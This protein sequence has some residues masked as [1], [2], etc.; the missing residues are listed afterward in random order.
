M[1]ARART[2]FALF[3][4]VLAF[5]LCMPT[6]AF[7]AGAFDDGGQSGALSSGTQRN[8]G[9]LFA[10]AHPVSSTDIEGDLYWA[11]QTLNATKVN[12]GTS[13]QGSLL[14]AGK[15]LSFSDITVAGSLRAAGQEITISR[16]QISSNITIA[17]QTISLGSD[18]AAKGLYASA[19]DITVAGSYEGGMLS[20]KNV[21]L[22]GVVE[23]DLTIS[24]QT[25]AIS[26]KAQVNGTLIVPE[27][28]NITIAE[29]AQ[30]PNVSY[31]APVKTEQPTMFDD[32]L[33]VLYTCMAHI[34]LVGLFFLVIRKSLVRS[35]NMART[36]LLKML[37]AGLVIFIVAPILCIVLV[38]P[39]ITIPIVV[40]MLIVML[41][42]ALF[43]LPFAG[44]ALGLMLLGKRMNPVLAAIIGTVALTILVYIPILSVVTVLFCIFFTTGYLWCC[45]WESHQ[46]RKRE[47]LEARQEAFATQQMGE[48]AN[49]PSAPSPSVPA[50]PTGDPVVPSDATEDTAGTPES[51]Q[52]KPTS[53]S[54]D[55]HERSS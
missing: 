52:E 21:N 5:M 24:A 27:D 18:V 13:G 54:G 48:A 17:A 50:P 20:A 55:Y 12:V 14:A 9:N 42:I 3:A 47:R 36:K 41:L 23:G 37:L 10:L 30:V 1:I 31:S 6:F 45:Y 16:A 11:G 4:A 2:K 29:G 44:S 32:L 39:L 34:V 40:L 53:L 19:Q 28:V 46:E 49:A 22:D 15:D 8:A 51:D 35:A 38:F 43:S 26:E 33:M 25:V 7:A